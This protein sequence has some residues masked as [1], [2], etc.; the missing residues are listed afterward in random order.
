[1]QQFVESRSPC[2]GAA[3]ALVYILSYNLVAALLSEGSEFNPLV[4][5]VLVDS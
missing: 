5:R 4:L 1:M 3:Y 2:L